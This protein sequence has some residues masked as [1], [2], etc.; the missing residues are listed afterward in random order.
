MPAMQPSTAP[1]VTGP[2]N[3]QK[4][5]L[6]RKYNPA[7]FDKVRAER[8]TYR[9][10]YE[11]VLWTYAEGLCRTSPA[12]LDY[13]MSIELP[14]HFQPDVFVDLELFVKAILTERAKDYPQKVAA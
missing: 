13:L 10:A 1:T 6:P 14:F 8:D 9:S 5:Y 2:D 4:N 11:H 7:E 3:I 12:R